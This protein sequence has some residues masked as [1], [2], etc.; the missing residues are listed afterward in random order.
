MRGQNG[1]AAALVVLTSALW[2][3]EG[4]VEEEGGRLEAD[5]TR[6]GVARGVS[7]VEA[8]AKGSTDR[9]G[10]GGSSALGAAAGV[11][12]SAAVGSVV[13]DTPWG[14]GATGFSLP[15]GAT[16][17]PLPQ[18]LSAALGGSLA[19]WIGGAMGGRGALE[20]AEVTLEGAC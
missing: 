8:E 11:G 15:L 7:E 13:R 16:D 20:G 19:A 4:E 12:K 3:E 17:V 14:S 10:G 5:W 18:L 9:G 6:R 2:L 1:A